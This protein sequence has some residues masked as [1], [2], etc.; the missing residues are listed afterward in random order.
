VTA[1]FALAAMLAYRVSGAVVDPDLWHQMALFRRALELGYL[2][3]RDAFA[4]TPTVHPSVHHEWGAGAIGYAVAQGFDGNGLIALRYA[5]VFGLAALCW[6]VARARQAPYAVLVPLSMLAIRLVDAGFS[7]V[8]AQ[9]YSFAL[10]AVLLLLLEVDQ[11]GKRW[12]I[13]P[14]LGL[15]VVWV[16]LHAGFLV[17][18]GLFFVH[19]LEM[20]LRGA[21]HRH[22]LI[23]GIA[24][25]PLALLSPYHVHY[26]AY[27][28]RAVT[29]ERPHIHEWTG[30]WMSENRTLSSFYG[31]SLLLLAYAACRAGWRNTR[32][33]MLVLVT[34][35]VALQS[36]RMVCVYGIAWLC[37]TPAYLAATPLGE[38]IQRLWTRRR[39]LQIGFWAAMTLVFLSAGW[40][41]H[42]WRLRIPSDRDPRLPNHVVYPVGAVDYLAEHGFAGN[43]LVGFDWGGY[44]LW[45]LHPRVKV[46]MDGRYE[47]AYAPEVEAEQ[48]AFFQAEPGWQQLLD[49][50]SYRA[51]DAI[52]APR[53]LGSRIH[54]KLVELLGWKRVYRDKTFELFARESSDLPLVDQPDAT[55]EGTFP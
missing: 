17:G 10:L 18:V 36:R 35:V 5:L 25:V 52:L 14:W 41:A 45:K 4:Y 37:Y 32:G 23:V 24:M 43:L 19:W 28:L 2:P 46:S 34:A 11:R 20:W 21:P 48:Y 55:F 50:P 15:Y 39:A 53:F 9:M 51:T 16:N 42:P 30:L 22:L 6:S 47:V 49:Q 8:R 31:S 3:L 1:T 26:A 40:P 13:G 29:M 7:P 12:W 44:V 54:E 33:L 27:L 38:S